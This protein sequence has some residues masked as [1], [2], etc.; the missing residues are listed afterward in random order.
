VLLQPLLER[1]RADIAEKEALA[2]YEHLIGRHG[3]T[4]TRLA[5]AG[6]ARFGDE[7][8]DVV[9]DGDWIDPGCEVVV[10]SARGN[11]IV[12]LPGA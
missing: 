4:V 5:P 11:R 2:N 3:K 1:E 10:I 8:L 9:S 12:V 6:K 7:V